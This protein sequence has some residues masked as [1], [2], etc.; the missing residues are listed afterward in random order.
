MKKYSVLLIV[1]VLF[2]L[3]ACGSGDAKENKVTKQLIIPKSDH[4]AH[5]FVSGVDSEGIAS[6]ETKLINSDITTVKDVLA[7][8]NRLVVK[9]PK[10]ENEIESVKQLD[11]QGSYILAFG[12]TK[13]FRGETYTIYMMKDGAFYYQDTLGSKDMVYVTVEEHK[14]ILE[15]IKAKLNVDF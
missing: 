13:D 2:I 15:K 5:L 1:A 11:K 14:D 9:K 8:V 10:Y 4:Y 6:D 3:S 7:L 12:D